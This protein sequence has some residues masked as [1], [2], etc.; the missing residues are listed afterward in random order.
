MIRILIYALSLLLLAILQPTTV[1]AFGDG[2]DSGLET[3]QPKQLRLKIATLRDEDHKLGLSETLILER[4]RAYLGRYGLRLAPQGT[5]DVIYLAVRIQTRGGRACYADTCLVRGVF[6]P[7]LG[8]THST[9]AA[10]WCETGLD[11]LQPGA[12]GNLERMLTLLEETL[13][14]FVR[15]YMQANK[16]RLGYETR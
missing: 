13:D 7:E 15:E 2:L 3:S 12:P 11:F 10:V 16:E 8:R 14:S 5:V 4:V 6:F 9:F 1:T